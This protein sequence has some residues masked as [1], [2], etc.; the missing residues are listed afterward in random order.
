MS[1]ICFNPSGIQM[2]EKTPNNDSLRWHQR[3]ALELLWGACC[4]IGWMPRWFKYG[5]LQPFVY[6]LLRM[7]RYRYKVMYTNISL[8]FPEKSEKEVK[9]IIKGAYSNLAEVIVDTICLAGAKRRNDLDHV[10]WIDAD[11]H[12]ERN[13]GRDWIF[14]ASHYGCWE[15]FLLWTLNDPDC[16]IFGVYH[17]L[18]STI[19]E[20]FY[21]RLRNFSP[22]IH[23]VPMQ[24]TV[25]QYLKNRSAGKN[26]AL[27]LIS[28]QTPNLRPDTEWF[29]FLNRKTAFIDGSEKLAMRF[30]IP[31]YYAHIERTRAD[32]LTIRFDEIYDGVEEVEPMEITRRYAAA[33]EAMI[34]ERPELWMWSH[35]RWKHS[36]EKQLQRYGKMTPSGKR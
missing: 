20:H 21:R 4:L 7:I 10:T 13:K 34:K 12:I 29:D 24:E 9:Q 5:M 15:Y 19:F 11:K 23:Q 35:K 26:V 36:P 25:R 28:D 18:K 14:M 6:A 32:H 2:S 22:K 16:E 33:L 31:V 3:L 17:P 27:G 30:N 8:S 1:Y